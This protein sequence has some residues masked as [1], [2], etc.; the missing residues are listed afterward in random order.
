M[1]CGRAREWVSNGTELCQFAGF[2]VQP[3][4]QSNNEAEEPFCYGNKASLEASNWFR[5]G[6]KPSDLVS[7]E[8]FL[9]WLKRLTIKEMLSWGTALGA[10]LFLLM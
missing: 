6:N 2:S 4:S 3:A 5:K 10:G 1:M 7:E 8:D 9:L